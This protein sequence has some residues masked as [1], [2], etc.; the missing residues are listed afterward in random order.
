MDKNPAKPILKTIAETGISGAGHDSIVASPNG[1][2]LWIV[3]H[4]HAD[5]AHP[6]ENGIVNADRLIF[7]ADGSMHV[8]PTRSCNRCPPAHPE[9]LLLS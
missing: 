4:M 5:P 7:G 9:P 2:E 1:K 6:S 3:Y 8:T